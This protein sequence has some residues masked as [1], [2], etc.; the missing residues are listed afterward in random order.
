ML[1]YLYLQNNLI[2]NIPY[3]DLSNLTKL[4]LDNNAIQYVSGLEA[5]VKLE[6][7]HVA[8]QRLPS[9]TSINFDEI[10]LEALSSTLQVLEISGNSIISLEPFSKLRNLRKFLCENNQIIDFGTLEAVVTLRYIEE[11]KFTGNP[12]CALKGYKDFCIG[13]SSESL[14]ILDDIPLQKHQQ[15]A[16][17]GLQA[18][19]QKIGAALSQKMI[20]EREIEYDGG[21]LEDMDFIDSGSL[22]D[23]N[24]LIGDL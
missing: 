4:Y 18:H 3:L 11:V 16:M 21:S 14:L 9:F 22:V 23:G 6:E 24:K 15:I 19:R 17:R 8:N 10:T 13:S 5:C 1:S 2:L 7:L 20:G 12:C